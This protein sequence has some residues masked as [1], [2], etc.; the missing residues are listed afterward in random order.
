MD[1]GRLEST[2]RQQLAFVVANIAEID[3]GVPHNNRLL[4][5][6]S[7]DGREAVAKIYFEDDRHRLEREDDGRVDARTR[8]A[9]GRT[10]K[11]Q[12]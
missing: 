2:L 11:V 12:S 10:L 3:P 5:L 7:S 4:H 9:P 1:T 6:W 8:H